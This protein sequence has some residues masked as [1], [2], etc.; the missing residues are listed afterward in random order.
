M[1]TSSAGEARQHANAISACVAC[2]LHTPVRLVFLVRGFS[3]VE[4]EE[5]A[6]V[7]KVAKGLLIKSALLTSLALELRPVLLLGALQ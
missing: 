3:P 6:A 7:V 4:F 2:T 1:E 5:A